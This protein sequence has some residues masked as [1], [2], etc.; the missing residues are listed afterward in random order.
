ML[1]WECLDTCLSPGGVCAQRTPVLNPVN[2]P[3]V[4]WFSV[5]RAACAGSAHLDG[6]VQG[7]GTNIDLLFWINPWNRNNTFL[8]AL[9]CSGAGRLSILCRV[10]AVVTAMWK[11]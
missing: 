2:N 3:G 5:H 9:Q 10:L 11:V 4:C 1:L 8:V 7:A 6:S